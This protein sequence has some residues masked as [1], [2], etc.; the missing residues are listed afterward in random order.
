MSF[1]SI[2][3]DLQKIISDKTSGS[4]ELLT[5][6]S[7]YLRNHMSEINLELILELENQFSDFQTIQ[8]F[9]SDL[10]AAVL[11]NSIKEFLTNQDDKTKLI[12]ENIYKN[13][14][15]VIK[16]FFSFITISNSKTFFEVM[17]LT[18]VDK[19][20][21]H[22]IISE[23]RPMLEGKI[24]AESLASDKINTSLITEAQIF[25]AVQK[26]DCGVVGAD[27]ILKNGNVVNKVGSNLLALACKE[28]NKPF[29]VIADKTK[30]SRD[31]S[32]NTKEMPGEEISSVKNKKIKIDNYYFEEIPKK[33]ITK[34]ITD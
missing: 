31:N 18:A 23:S 26:C 13:L 34:I 9:L 1:D 28:F 5:A 10:R 30:F 11:N 2:P 24:L 27:K 32:F 7:D 33:Y 6:L 21:I 19:A 17:K 12:F 16:D 14:K 4:R 29:F 15:P 8:N 20:S 25:N 22:I 3:E